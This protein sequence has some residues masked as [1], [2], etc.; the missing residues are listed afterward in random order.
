[1]KTRAIVE[2]NRKLLEILDPPPFAIWA[3]GELVGIDPGEEG[4]EESGG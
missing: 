1:M 2:K 4:G 3:R